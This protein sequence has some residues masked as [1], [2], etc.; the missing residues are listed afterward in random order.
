MARKN[1]TTNTDRMWCYAAFALVMEGNE[2]R[3]ASELVDIVHREFPKFTKLVYGNNFVQAL[4][5]H[6]AAHIF[7]KEYQRRDLGQVYYLVPKFYDI[8]VGQVRSETKPLLIK[9]KE[10]QGQQAIVT[11]GIRL[12]NQRQE[13]S[14]HR[15][16]TL[17]SIFGQ[18]RDIY[19][20]TRR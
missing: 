3:Y 2:A 7:N 4:S 11:A 1:I 19:E 8:L 10:E 6:D 20:G 5:C 16:P 13:K 15:T 9:L 18:A 12:L 14:Y 17:I